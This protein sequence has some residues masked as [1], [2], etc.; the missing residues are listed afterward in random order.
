MR[1]LKIKM[2]YCI[3]WNVNFN[4]K[5]YCSKL[6]RAMF[7]DFYSNWG[8]L[9][10]EFENIGWSGR[11]GS[12][13]GCTLNYYRFHSNLVL[14]HRIDRKDTRACIVAAYG[15]STKTY[16]E[17]VSYKLCGN[18]VRKWFHLLV[19]NDML[20]LVRPVRSRKLR[21]ICGDQRCL[22]RVSLLFL[23]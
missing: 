16:W 18:M 6:T 21:F 3:V 12:I 14:C 15:R 10:W 7:I 2:S 5:H 8:M 4:E 20:L 22:Q 17:C 23:L 13:L 9:F 19:L 1:S 11:N